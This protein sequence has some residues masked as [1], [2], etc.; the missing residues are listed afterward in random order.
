MTTALVLFSWFV[1]GLGGTLDL[2]M[3]AVAIWPAKDRVRHSTVPVVGA[4]FYVFAG[5]FRMAVSLT[6]IWGVVA[7]LVSI[8]FVGHLLVVP[9]VLRRR[10]TRARRRAE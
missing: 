4:V 6:P 3:F 7:V 9:E 5:L 1:V 8:H 10:S 2:S